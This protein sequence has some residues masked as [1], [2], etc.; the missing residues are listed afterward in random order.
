MSEQ[1]KALVALSPI[2]MFSFSESQDII[3][4]KLFEKDPKKAFE[5]F[6]AGISSEF[7]ENLK[8]YGVESNDLSNKFMREHIRQ[9]AQDLTFVKDDEEF[10]KFISEF[11]LFFSKKRMKFSFSK[12]KFVVQ[13][14]N[15]LEDL[16]RI[17]NLMAERL[18]EWFGMHYPECRLS[19]KDLVTHVASFGTR[20]NFPEFVES[21]G[22]EISKEDEEVIKSYAQSIERVNE[23][24]HRLEKYIRDSMHELAPNTSTLIDEL[25]LAKL[26]AAAGS[27]EKLA[28]M[29]ASSIQ[30]IGAE[31]ALFRHLKKQGKSPKFGLI[32]M[33]SWIQNVSDE[34]KGK[35][36]R[37]LSAKLMQ[38]VRIDFYSGRDESARLKKELE[39]DIKKISG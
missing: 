35:V 6:E 27:L 7:L 20:E 19:M 5:Q 36:A 3:Y 32:F 29:S 34:E 21:V 30:L 10:N 4:F 12:D 38:S 17:T 26:L 25:L 15:A 31:K 18:K 9:L 33:S 22:L 14:N 1:K 23:E 28:R 11:S 39:H 13:A 16:L 24:K 8:E 37:I 2:G